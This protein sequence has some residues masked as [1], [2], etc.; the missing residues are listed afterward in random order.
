MIGLSILSG[1]ND[2][3]TQY[4]ATGTLGA[5]GTAVETAAVRLAKAAFDT[6]VITA[7]WQQ[8]GTIA[9]DSSQLSAIKRMAS[10]IDPA[11]VTDTGKAVDVQNSFVIYKALDRLQVLAEAAGKSTTSDAERATLEKAF[12]KGLADIKSYL[13]T[14]QVDQLNLAFGEATRNAQTVGVK[15]DVS[16]GKT[17]AKPVVAT[18]D[19]PI[20]GLTGTEV[21]Q[22]TLGKYNL[23]DT[24]TVDLST[25]AQPPT[26]DGIAAALN[27]ALAA[28]PALDAGGNPIVDANGNPVSRWQTRFSVQKTGDQWGLAY[29]VAGSEAV[30][31]DQLAAPDALM[32]IGGQTALNAS[33][34]MGVTKLID[35][36]TGLTQSNPLNTISAIDRIATEQA[37]ALAAAN[38]KPATTGTTTLPV[39]DP[40][41]K[42]AMDVRAT[43]TD[44][45]GY[46]Y[47]VGTTAGDLGANRSDGG[48]DLF[49]TKLDSEGNVVWQRTL[50]V[51]GEAKGAAI[52]VDAAGNV[53][54]AGTIT[55][56]HDGSLGLD[57]D[58]LV[59]RF[60]GAGEQTF[61][62][63]VPALGDDV[64]TAVAIDAAGTIYVGGQSATNGGDAF[65]GRLDASGK[66]QERRTFAAAGSGSVTA[67]A[68]DGNG[69]LLALTRESGAASL[70][71]IDGGALATDLG[72]IALGAVDARAI[73]VSSTGAIAVAGAASVAVAGTQANAISGGRDGFVTQIDSALSATVTTYLGTGADDQVDSV[74]FMDGELYVGG[75]TSG[76]LG[77]ALRGSV[78]GF[79][80]HVATGTGAIESVTQFGRASQRAEAVQLAAVTGGGGN[81]GALGLHRGSLVAEDSTRLVS[82]TGLNP[83]D[84]FGIVRDDG[85][86]TTITIGATDTM[87][88]LADKVRRLLGSSATISTPKVDGQ[89]TLKIT[90]QNGHTVTL[91]AGPDGTDALAKLGLAPARLYAAPTRAATAPI[92][93]PGGSFGLGLSDA[94]S[95]S[96]KAGAALALDKI[97]T[98]VSIVQTA[99]RSLYWDATK[100][101]LVN[102]ST[103]YQSAT[104]N[105]YLQSQ[106]ANYQAALD[107]LTA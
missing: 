101:S 50:G 34:V 99:Y 100:E 11:S 77:G 31:I 25:I 88:T 37:K 7:P 22:I 17:A 62:T 12:Q 102:G 9:A 66:L 32:V 68:I 57:S 97:K 80:G 76:A 26:L 13:S 78:D 40:T 95:L 18:R 16:T 71:R 10:I 55:G 52:T 6:P 103:G 81:L 54:V 49:L 92:V 105:A 59:A 90:V 19:A 56:P 69:D 27:A 85:K 36:A 5:D 48:D 45:A 89:T 35:P 104:P 15:P 2:Y 86:V 23:S 1:T 65:I 72:S 79:V 70:R 3:L 91:L 4:Y 64:A 75:R 82:Q 53:V 24:L 73:A 84:G 38:A 43:A 41:V 93:S 74:V 44:A 61:L 20:P 96:S 29:E 8:P 46:T 107:R 14:A 83:G 63:T 28:P 30:S 33:T 98:A 51:A 67:L 47:V 42:A 21:L 39:V 106:L 87:T 60:T 94:L 58:M